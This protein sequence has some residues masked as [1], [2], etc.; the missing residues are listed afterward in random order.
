MHIFFH[1]PKCAG[2]TF[3]NLLEVEVRAKT[4]LSVGGME[5][6]AFLPDSALNSVDLITGHVGIGLLHRI[7]QPYRSL[8]FLR[9]P[10]SRV[11]SQY[12]YCKRL[13]ETKAHRVFG[14]EVFR[15]NLVD[16]LR[17]KDDPIVASLF[18]NTMTWFFV[19]DWVDYYRDSSISDQNALEIAK[20]NILNLDFFGI[21]EQFDWSLKLANRTFGWALSNDYRLNKTEIDQ[22]QEN[23]DTLSELVAMNNALDLELYEWACSVF[24]DRTEAMM[25]ER[26][27]IVANDFSGIGWNLGIRCDMDKRGQF[28]FVSSVESRIPVSIGDTVTF[29]GAGESKVLGVESVEQNGRLAVFVTVDRILDPNCDGFPNAILVK[30]A[31]RS[32]CNV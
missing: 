18:R 28:Y 22:V 14:R 32:G 24:L 3:R 13:S 15:G 25:G 29:A 17:T 7:S 12:N 4:V 11:I 26:V 6:I 8:T 5:G 16:I 1:V 27:R 23:D 2:T 20:Q 10:I 19:S 21:T 31:C 30:P 9:N